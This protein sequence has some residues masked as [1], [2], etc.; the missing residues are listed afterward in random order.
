MLGFLARMF[1]SK[2]GVTTVEYALIAALIAVAM[3]AGIGLVSPSI[4]ATF[5]A[6][7]ET[8]PVD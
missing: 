1:V 3:T 8:A 7:S 5:K 6:A 4:F 2:T